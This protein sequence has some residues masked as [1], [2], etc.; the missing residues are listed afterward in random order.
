M[1]F[2]ELAVGRAINLEISELDHVVVIDDRRFWSIERLLKVDTS[3]TDEALR[4][5]SRG[6]RC[7]FDDYTP[8]WLSHGIP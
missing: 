3:Q 4:I 8:L 5:P 2:P 6:L 1:Q 7:D